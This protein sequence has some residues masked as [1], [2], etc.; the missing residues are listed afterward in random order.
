MLDQVQLAAW[1]PRHV[2]WVAVVKKMGLA[3]S[4]WELGRRR[5]FVAAGAEAISLHLQSH[6][7]DEGAVTLAPK[8]AE[9]GKGPNQ[10]GRRESW[11]AGEP[12]REAGMTTPLQEQVERGP[13]DL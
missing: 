5:V 3:A 11:L 2:A 4:S 13:S 10:R 7:W 8:E 6:I 1:M 12:W 9:E